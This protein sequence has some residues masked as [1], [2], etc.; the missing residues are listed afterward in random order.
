MPENPEKPLMPENPLNP[1]IPE[2]PEI[3]LTT[4]KITGRSF[5]KPVVPV[6]ADVINV[7]GIVQYVPTLVGVPV[8][9]HV[10]LFALFD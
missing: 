3:P 7:T 6:P 2:Y 8:T 4:A 1:D 5:A 9:C 10:W